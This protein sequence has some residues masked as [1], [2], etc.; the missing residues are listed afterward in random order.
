MATPIT[1][2]INGEPIAGGPARLKLLDDTYL[3]F[4]HI[5]KT[6][7][8]SIT[9]WLY[10]NVYKPKLV[11]RFE[12]YNGHSTR[13]LIEKTTSW[14]NNLGKTFVVV[15]NPYLRYISFWNYEQ[16]TTKKE[17]S[18]EECWNTWKTAKHNSQRMYW[19]DSDIVLR[20]E[21]LQSEMQEKIATPFFNIKC[22]LPRRNFLGVTY[23]VEDIDNIIPK[24]LRDVIYYQDEETF[25]KFGYERDV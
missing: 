23:N 25:D 1:R 5:P 19:K 13:T 3:T 7:G 24:N 2:T 12:S 17:M 11:K 4:I 14:G 21:N 9:F 22:D 20:Y 15:R 8:T 6:G 16:Y 18:F 10:E